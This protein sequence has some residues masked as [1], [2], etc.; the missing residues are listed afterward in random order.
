MNPAMTIRSSG[1]SLKRIPD[2]LDGDPVFRGCSC[3]DE[4]Y[5][6]PPGRCLIAAPENI[7]RNM[8]R[9]G[10]GNVTLPV[11]WRKNSEAWNEIPE[12]RFALYVLDFL[13]THPKKG[14]DDEKQKF[15]T[16]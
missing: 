15:Y 11:P 14:T 12:N 5:S 6:A 13:R 7:A 2:M 16:H 1:R 8:N 10:T 4:Q 9:I 3:V